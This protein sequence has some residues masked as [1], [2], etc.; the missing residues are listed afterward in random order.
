MFNKKLVFIIL[1]IVS[2][3]ILYT[4][5]K[6]K[7]HYTKPKYKGL[8]LFDI[9]GTLTTGKENYAVVKYCID[10]NYAVGISTA[11]GIYNMKNLQHYKWM[12]KNL[13]TF[14]KNNKN[15]TFN[16]VRSG[17]LAGEYNP[18]I[19]SK[20][21]RKFNSYTLEQY[22]YA[23]GLSMYHTMKALKLSKESKLILCDDLKEFIEGYL[24]FDKTY[25]YV[26]CGD[27]NGLT[28]DK[29]KMLI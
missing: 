23:K 19:Y 9:D 13:L 8:V 10:N 15:V 26:Y 14:I 5:S 6:T 24:M 29:I 4:L 22:G 18:D 20:I 16:N 27:N 21:Y 12:P 11:G 3:I 17:Y 1:V 28:L 2:L 25:Q 7:E